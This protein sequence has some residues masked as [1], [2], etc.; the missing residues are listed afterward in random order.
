MDGISARDGVL[1]VVVF[2]KK[3]TTHHL[4]H[5]AVAFQTALQHRDSASHTEMHTSLMT[6]QMALQT[7]R[8]SPHVQRQQSLM[9]C[10]HGVQH[11]SSIH[12]QHSPSLSQM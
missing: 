5:V 11:T 12:V 8:S 3:K 1:S 10:M 2:A 9:A 4:Q 7:S 6:P